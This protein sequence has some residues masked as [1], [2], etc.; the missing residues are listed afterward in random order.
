MSIVSVD[1]VDGVAECAV[2]SGKVRL[3]QWGE[4]V[5]VVHFDGTTL[6]KNKRYV[7]PLA[8]YIVPTESLR[9]R[10]AMAALTGW[11]ARTYD[12]PERYA[13]AAYEV[14][15]AMLKE[16]VREKSTNGRDAAGVEGSG[17]RV[18]VG[19]EA[20]PAEGGEE[21]VAG[22]VGDSPGGCP[23]EHD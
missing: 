3:E 19:N 12:K 18:P 23:P 1:G 22:G 2:C 17:V 4:S 16:R 6:C 20:G 9:D 14:A 5:R 15:D 8:D 21:D 10:F 7:A 13:L 11:V